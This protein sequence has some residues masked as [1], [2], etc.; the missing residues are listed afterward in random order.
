MALCKQFLSWFWSSSLLTKLCVAFGLAVLTAFLGF[1]AVPLA[2]ALGMLLAGAIAYRL[3][4]LRR[5]DA[6]QSSTKPE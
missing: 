3:L 6:E 4:K 5:R 1:L 2:I